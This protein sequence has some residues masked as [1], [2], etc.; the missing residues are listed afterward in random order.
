MLG[1]DYPFPLGESRV[2]KLV[3]NSRSL[4]DAQRARILGGNA[5]R[6]FGLS[7]AHAVSN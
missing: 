1:S 5:E 6:F 3:R 4:S 7:T 2:G